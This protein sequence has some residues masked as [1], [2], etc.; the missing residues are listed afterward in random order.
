MKGIIKTIFILTI[1]ALSWITMANDYVTGYATYTMQPKETLSFA[2]NYLHYKAYRNVLTQELKKL[3]LDAKGFW[4]K[5][6]EGFEQSFKEHQ[7]RYDKAIA[8]AKT[9]DAKQQTMF[10]LKEYKLRK[11]KAFGGLSH[12]VISDAIKS[13]GS[14]YGS[15]NTKTMTIDAKL[16]YKALRMVYSR[17]MIDSLKTK[18]FDQ[19]VVRGNF[20]WGNIDF[21]KIGNTSKV[22]LEN[23]IVKG[24]KEWFS[25]NTNPEK[26]I[27]ALDEKEASTQPVSSRASLFIGV[28]ARADEDKSDAVPI[29]YQ[30]SIALRDDKTQDFI[31]FQDISEV[32]KFYPIPTDESQRMTN[33][34]WAT[35]IPHFVTLRSLL[36][37]SILTENTSKVFVRNYKHIDDVLKIQEKLKTI[38]IG[39]NLLS[40]ID[41]FQSSTASL[42]LR[43]N[44]D[45]EKLK[46][47]LK[48]V[49]NDFFPAE[50]ILEGSETKTEEATE[51]AM[52]S[53][54]SIQ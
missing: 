23:A 51:S 21:S 36:E 46:A 12:V 35:P 40:D 47:V 6:D 31:F 7:E 49:Q 10:S 32:L 3:G 13:F 14:K 26:P 4:A 38:G 29:H 39:I 43:Y 5:Y 48:T 53:K 52:N 27:T 37:R 50:L 15:T 8:G 19:V 17:F 33:D 25:Q 24:W 11:Q 16:N 41:Y 28:R 9:L 30:F 1:S 20:D 45:L 34:V 54:K 2:K 18:S 42:I 22:D 44:G